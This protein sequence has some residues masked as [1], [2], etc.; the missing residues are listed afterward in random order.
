M[1]MHGVCTLA[2]VIGRV[3]LYVGNDPT[4]RSVKRSTKSYV[5]IR[6][7]GSYRIE[8]ITKSSRVYIRPNKSLEVASIYLSIHLRDS[9]NLALMSA[10]EYRNS[11][12]L[13]GDFRLRAHMRFIDEVIPR[14]NPS[15]K[16]VLPILRR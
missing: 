6:R 8:K 14:I 11:I 13:P 1:N 3:W 2:I 15:L 10:L 16:F 7:L 9:R 4:R 5:S 12:L